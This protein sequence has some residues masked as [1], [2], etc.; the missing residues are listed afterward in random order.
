[1]NDCIPLMINFP[2]HDLYA[3]DNLEKIQSAVLAI[4]AHL[5]KIRTTNYPPKRAICLVEAISRDLNIQ[6]LKVC[7]QELLLKMQHVVKCANSPTYM[8]KWSKHINSVD[9][10]S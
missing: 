2:I 1:M 10:I 8:S 9:G 7:N 6:L 4:Y 3:A 5:R